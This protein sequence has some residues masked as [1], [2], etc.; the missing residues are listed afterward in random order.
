MTRIT[1]KDVAKESGVSIA[2]VSRVL[3]HKGY[4]TE[5][6]KQKVYT[7]VEKL[8][9]QPNA[10]AR[11]LKIEQ[12]NTIGIIIPDISNPYFMKIS[13]GIEDVV[14]SK[15]YNLIFGS[16]DESPD[17]ER[18]LL[19]VLYKKRVDAL[20]L[21]TSGANEEL[22]RSIQATGTPVIL[23][24]RRLEE[25]DDSMDLIQEDNIRGAYMLT[26]SL[27]LQGHERIGV[28]H[29]PTNVSTGADRYAGYLQAMRQYHSPVEEE[30]QFFGSF[31]RE[32]GEK[33]TQYF[34]QLDHRPSAL[35]CFNN[36]MAYGMMLELVQRGCR[37]QND[38][39]LACY[40]QVEAAELLWP[41]MISIR[42][43]P[44]EMGR[45][46]GRILCER[47]LERGSGPYKE[48]FKP[49]M[50]GAQSR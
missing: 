21:A 4:A 42:Q 22:I 26:E 36:T 27:I 24:D 23:I 25:E 37:L 40:G 33:A 18:E 3:N 11:S 46:A 48:T 7:A 1:I 38:F 29:G 41:D 9:Y 12:T 34:L 2:T 43:S 20:V 30:L 6:V 32:S 17:K 16:G 8:N 49:I 31:T 45:A 39:I 44:Y 28:V 47:L 14:H 19:Q 13:K 50:T 35:L 10:V 15:G 5:E